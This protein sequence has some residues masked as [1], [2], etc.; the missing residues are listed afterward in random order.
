MLLIFGKIKASLK[1]GVAIYRISAKSDTPFLYAGVRRLKL[2]C[3]MK[4]NVI[5]LQGLPE[6]C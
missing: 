2:L 5:Y 6:S 1:A 3:C 4:F